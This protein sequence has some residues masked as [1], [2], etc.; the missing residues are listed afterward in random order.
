MTTTK[1]LN[2]GAKMTTTNP[3]V[4]LPVEIFCD[5]LGYYL[6]WGDM[7]RFDTAFL[8]RDTRNS[9]LFAS[10]LRKVKGGRIGSGTR[11]FIEE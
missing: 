5:I 8:N 1:S 6:D 11:L 4:T 9:Y 10:Q 2:V 3:L 7:G